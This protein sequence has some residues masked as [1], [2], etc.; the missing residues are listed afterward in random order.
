M[1]SV[2]FPLFSELVFITYLASLKLYYEEDLFGLGRG[3]GGR[4]GFD[5]K[6]AGLPGNDGYNVVSGAGAEDAGGRD[7]GADPAEGGRAEAGAGGEGGGGDAAA[8]AGDTAS[9]DGLEAAEKGSPVDAGE[10]SF[11]VDSIVPR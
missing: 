4:R 10:V 3:G 8:A 2:F 11:G 6:T 5:S 1:W 9:S 7:S